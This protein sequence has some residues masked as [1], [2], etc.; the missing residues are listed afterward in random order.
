MKTYYI[1]KNT[2]E[3]HCLNYIKKK[4]NV[5]KLYLTKLKYSKYKEDENFLLLF[6]F[7]NIEKAKE[8]AISKKYIKAKVCRHCNEKIYIPRSYN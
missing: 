5:D 8:K 3:I 2:S 6:F 1:N 7:I 4:C